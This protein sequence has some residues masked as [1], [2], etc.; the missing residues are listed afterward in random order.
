MIIEWIEWTLSGTENMWFNTIGLLP[1]KSDTPSEKVRKTIGDLD[2][3]KKALVT[4]TDMVV[5]EG[6]TDMVDKKRKKP[7]MVE[8]VITSPIWEKNIINT[9]NKID[10]SQECNK[11]IDIPKSNKTDIL[12][13]IDKWRSTQKYD[14]EN[15]LD[16]S[17]YMPGN[18]FSYI[19]TRIENPQQ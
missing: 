12:K 17:I 10:K 18:N 3:T 8:K 7:I 1:K 16:K 9:V 6:N 2:D 15:T 4:T 14:I 5:K 13:S 11:E 19:S